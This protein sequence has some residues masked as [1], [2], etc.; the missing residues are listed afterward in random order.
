MRDWSHGVYGR[1][2]DVPAKTGPARP[3]LG[4]EEERN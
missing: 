2:A 3:R 1:G 4:G